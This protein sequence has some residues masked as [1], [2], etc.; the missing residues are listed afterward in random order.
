MDTDC[1][2][3]F[4]NVCFITEHMTVLRQRVEVPV[5]KKRGGFISNYE[6]VLFTQP[7]NYHSLTESESD[8]G[9]REIL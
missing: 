1:C 9:P 7:P 4:A 8:L 6:K 3:G 2:A 5:P